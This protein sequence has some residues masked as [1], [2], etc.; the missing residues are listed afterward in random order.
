M[1]DDDESPPRPPPGAIDLPRIEKAVREI[2]E[3]VGEDA[4]RDGLLD[5]PARVARMYAEVFAGLHEDPAAHLVVTLSL[6]HI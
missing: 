6:I 5:T 3:A 4:D 1:F 2:L